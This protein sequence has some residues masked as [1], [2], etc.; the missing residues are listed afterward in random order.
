MVS[1]SASIVKRGGWQTGGCVS[2]S[3]RVLPPWRH[4]GLPRDCQ[5]LC[6]SSPRSPSPRGSSLTRS[7]TGR[8]RGRKTW[9]IK[10]DTCQRLWRGSDHADKKDGWHHQPL[11]Q[12]SPTD[13]TATTNEL[14][15]TWKM[16]VNCTAA[17]H[18]G[19]PCCQRKCL[20]FF[21]FFLKEF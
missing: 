4:S 2:P 9:V 13:T 6:L 17:H 14:S 8:E 7:A 11:R 16:F 5:S 10:V 12:K 20:F 19:G 21:F 1:L 15:K 3:T 18:Q